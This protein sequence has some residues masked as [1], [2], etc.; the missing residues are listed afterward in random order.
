MRAVGIEAGKD[1]KQEEEDVD[2]HCIGNDLTKGVKSLLGNVKVREL[3]HN[4]ANHD[5]QSRTSSESRRQE[6]TDD[7]CG[8]P[9]CTARVADVN[10]CGNGMDADSQRDC[11]DCQNLSPL[12]RRDLLTLAVDSRPAHDDVHDQVRRK[13]AHVEEQDGVRR[14]IQDNVKQTLRI[15]KVGDNEQEGNQNSCNSEELAEDQHGAELLVVM[16]V[17]RDGYHNAR[18]CNADKE[19][20]LG[21]IKTPADVTAHAGE[22]QAVLKLIRIS[23]YADAD[24]DQQEANPAPVKLTAVENLLDHSYSPALM[25]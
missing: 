3:P 17:E 19:R 5:Q 24:A 13:N 22:D 16:Q 8:T 23:D 12:E 11:D 25:M 2:A 20:E 4:E 21:D 6:A 14:R 1:L 15:T 18:C 7:D 10:E 9:I